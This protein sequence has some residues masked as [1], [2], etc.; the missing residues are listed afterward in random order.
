MY[1]TYDPY[2]YHIKS[3]IERNKN[4]AWGW[5]LKTGFE[6]L[7]SVIGGLKPG[8]LY[9][10]GGRPGM[11]I[12]SFIYNMISNMCF[13]K[14][15]SIAVFSYTLS[16]W[17]ILN[18]LSSIDLKIELDNIVKNRL[19][20][21]QENLINEFYDRLSDLS[22]FI[23]ADENVS[24][25]ELRQR[26]ILLSLENDVDFIVI[27]RPEFLQA[28]KIEIL[29]SMAVDINVPILVTGTLD[30]RVEERG[31]DKRPVLSDLRCFG[32]IEKFFDAVLF[33][34]R[35]EYYGIV[36][37]E[38]GNSTAGNMELLVEKNR[39]GGSALLNY[40]FI[41]KYH[42]VGDNDKRKR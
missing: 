18:M 13:H 33:L 1:K 29:K 16:S 3:I 6:N 27:D 26:S 30:Q 5:G 4:I 23:D 34:Y 12:D 24:F 25:S 36:E 35:H 21:V 7:D 11:G 20:K 10:L 14:D 38:Y 17:T 37:D 32:G 40:E 19:T 2:Q 42:F 39:F 41:A 8:M 15:H 9:F 22:L 28:D 31:G